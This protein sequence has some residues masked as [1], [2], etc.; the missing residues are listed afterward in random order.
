MTSKLNRVRFA[1][2]VAG[3]QYAP[4]SGSE[5]QTFT[6]EWCAHCSKDKAMREGAALEDCDDNE[7]CSIIAYR[8]IER[9]DPEWIYGEDGQPK[10][11]AFHEFGMP[12][13]YRCA[14]TSDM[15]AAGK[16]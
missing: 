11:T 9:Q 6:S 8:L 3:Q 5:L 2:G 15:F 10:C 12:A 14:D 7:L 4:H 16:P 1:S 13:P